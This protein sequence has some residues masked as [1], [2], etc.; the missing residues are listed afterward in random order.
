[1]TPLAPLASAWHSHGADPEVLSDQLGL[2]S[3]FWAS[4]HRPPTGPAA[5]SMVPGWAGPRHLRRG[6]R[7]ATR[8]RGRGRRVRLAEE[9]VLDDD[10]PPAA[11]GGDE[12]GL[13]E[14]GESEHRGRIPD[15]P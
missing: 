9:Q 7:L 5:A 11:G 13:C 8:L 10:A 2:S 1:M 15:Q 14:P 6:A 3:V 4:G 12:G